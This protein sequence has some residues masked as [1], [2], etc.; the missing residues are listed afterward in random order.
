M[1]KETDTTKMGYKSF[2][3]VI[4]VLASISTLLK[5]QSFKKLNRLNGQIIICHCWP[6]IKMKICLYVTLN[7]WSSV[8]GADV[9]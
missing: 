5:Y 7:R 1:A 8:H 4:L 9:P 6:R 2:A 3:A